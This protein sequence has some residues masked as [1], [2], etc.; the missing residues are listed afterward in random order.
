VLI[1]G[2]HK[3]YSGHHLVLSASKAPQHLSCLSTVDRFAKHPAIQDNYAVS[4]DYEATVQR[5]GH[6]QGFG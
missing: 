2:I 6:A 3:G 1:G 4:A 5:P